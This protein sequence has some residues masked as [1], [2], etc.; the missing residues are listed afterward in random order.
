MH[1]NRFKKKKNYAVFLIIYL[2]FA[3]H[4]LLGTPY[5]HIGSPPAKLKR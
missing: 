1:N 5:G 4:N 3:S 2:Y